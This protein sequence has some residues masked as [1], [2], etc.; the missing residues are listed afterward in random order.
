MSIAEE[1]E[2]GNAIRNVRVLDKVEHIGDRNKMDEKEESK[3]QPHTEKL[4]ST[5][6]SGASDEFG[7]L[8]SFGKPALI[9]EEPQ[10][11]QNTNQYYREPT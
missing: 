6:H 1:R 5:R 10:D 3:S 4:Q 8:S 7:G 11:P 2:R 9:S